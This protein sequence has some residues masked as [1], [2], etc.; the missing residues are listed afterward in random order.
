MAEYNR[1]IVQ[2]P[3]APAART[4]IRGATVLSMDGD[5][6]NLARGDILI[7]GTTI[8]A[9][10]ENLE[11]GDSVVIEASGMIAMP[12]MVDTHRHSWEGQL[13]RI[14]PNAATLEDYCNATHFSFAKYYRPADMYIG[15]LLSALGCIDAG[16][17]TLVDNSHNSRTGEH[18]DAAVEAL[19]D[20]GIRA[21]HAS[22][23]PVAGEWDKAHW[24]GNLERLQEKYIKKG[25]N[26]LL[27]L[28]VMAQLGLSCGLRPDA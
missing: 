14:N 8:T 24:P 25:D 16:I 18:S 7:E 20:A 10:G 4:L 1:S 5:I 12:G 19:L 27:S 3:V 21:V 23:A 22:G 6:G 13:R 28:A 2:A 26:P 15:N 11:A 9:I 17:T